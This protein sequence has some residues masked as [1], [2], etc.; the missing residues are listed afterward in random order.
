MVPGKAAEGSPRAWDLATGLGR[1][2]WVL[3][4][5]LAIWEVKP[6]DGRS[7]VLSVSPSLPLC[8][9]NTFFNDSPHTEGMVFLCSS[10]IHILVMMQN[11]SVIT[12]FVCEKGTKNDLFYTK[13]T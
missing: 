13:V 6:A 12:D 11:M 10:G 9:A 4:P 2:C 5:W 8:L 3:S 1:P 7:G